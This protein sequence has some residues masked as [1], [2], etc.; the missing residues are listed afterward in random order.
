MPCWPL[1]PRLWCSALK[2]RQRSFLA[3]SLGLRRRDTS[4]VG[5]NRTYLG[6]CEVA[7]GTLAPGAHQ[8]RVVGPWVRSR[9][10]ASS[11]ACCVA[12]QFPGEFRARAPSTA[13]ARGND[14]RRH[15]QR[16]FASNRRLKW[17]LD[18]HS[19]AGGQVL[20]ADADLDDPR[21]IDPSHTD[22]FEDPVVNLAKPN[23]AKPRQCRRISREPRLGL[24]DRTG[25]LGDQDSNLD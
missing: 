18:A 8:P 9:R 5:V 22:V 6:R 20:L 19:L 23:Q 16:R 13:I 24:R 25:W 4:G 10:P 21:F 14:I 12:H 15:L 3:R 7:G 11:A 17:W 2:F 1:A